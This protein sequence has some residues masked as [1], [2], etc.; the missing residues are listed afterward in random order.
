MV[1]MFLQNKNSLLHKILFKNFGAKMWDESAKRGA[2][3]AWKIIK[4]GIDY[5]KPIVRWQVNNG[6]SIN[7]N[8]DNWILDRSLKRWPATCNTVDIDD[9]K[10]SF[11]MDEDGNRNS[12][13]L[14]EFFFGD[15]VKIIQQMEKGANNIEDRMELV[16][17]NT[18]KTISTLCAEA[19][20][21]QRDSNYNKYNW[22]KKLKL[23]QKVFLFWWR[24]LNGALPMKEW[25]S[26]R[27]LANSNDCLRGCH[28]N[29]DT[30]HVIIKCSMLKVLLQKLRSCGFNVPA[31]QNLDECTTAL[32]QAADKGL[33][34]IYA[35]AVYHSWRSRNMVKH[36]NSEILI[37]YAVAEIISYTSHHQSNPIE[38]TWNTNQPML[39]KSWCP[40]PHGWIKLNVDD[41]LSV[42]NMAGIAVVLRD[43]KG[44][45]KNVL[46]SLILWFLRF[47]RN[48]SCLMVQLWEHVVF[49]F[50]T[51]MS[52]ECDVVPQHFVGILEGFWFFGGWPSQ[53]DF[54]AGF[55]LFD[56]YGFLGA[57]SCAT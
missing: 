41:A 20:N 45:I 7:I 42:K 9:K 19:I 28:E 22:L 30:E 54:G 44:H 10:V 25:L 49:A 2:S 34:K 14:T 55:C 6:N 51:A 26:Y 36:D 13:K 17:T 46:P 37:A 33:V 56:L 52:L 27:R 8:A 15:M 3:T 24:V 31:F 48:N 11:L 50:V 21:F 57:H 39:S 43:C 23:D 5:L 47:E 4:E 18:G 40:P 53:E 38:K 1:W 16:H 29:E 35:F 32:K 12:E